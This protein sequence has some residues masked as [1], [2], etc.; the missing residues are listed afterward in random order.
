MANKKQK[1]HWHAGVNSEGTLNLELYFPDGA[2]ITKEQKEKVL[3]A[4]LHQAEEFMLSKGYLSPDVHFLSSSD[5]E[6]EYGTSRQYWEKLMNQG[7]IP[8]KETAAGRITT[9]LWVKG[10]LNNKEKVDKYVKSTNKQVDLIVS[11]G[12][13]SGRTICFECK[14]PK[15]EY[16]VNSES[17][18]GLCRAG[19]GFRIHTTHDLEKP[20][21]K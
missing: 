17:I 8:Y 2:D 16:F 1:Y 3:A 5:L 11:E 19:C 14:V 15:F 12:K 21:K 6:K 13:K 9:N 4:K 18:D 20:N 7:K 10:Y